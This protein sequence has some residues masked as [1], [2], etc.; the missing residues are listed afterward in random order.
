MAHDHRRSLERARSG[1][2]AALIAFC[3]LT[4][5]A[6]AFVDWLLTWHPQPYTHTFMLDSTLPELR[7]PAVVD[8]DATGLLSL[9]I[10][11]WTD[12][13]YVPRFQTDGAVITRITA[14]SMGASGRNGAM[15][16]CFHVGLRSGHDRDIT[17][18][19]D[20]LDSDRLIGS[21]HIKKQNLDEGSTTVLLGSVSFLQADFDTLKTEGAK[22]V[23]RVT[24]AIEYPQ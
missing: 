24:M 16:F 20:L 2:A 23:L 13:K 15:K 3:T 7:S 18:G 5:T 19:F 17:I 14:F 1:A 8:I 11:E 21:G 12:I 9:P 10:S 6:C 4:L 22:P